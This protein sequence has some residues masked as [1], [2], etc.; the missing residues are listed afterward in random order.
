MADIRVFTYNLRV[1]VPGDGKNSFTSRRAY[2]RDRFPGFQADIVGFQETIPHMRQWL[3]ENFPEY[4]VCGLGRE[5][6]LQ[7]E[8]NPILFRRAAFDLAELDCFW[9]SDT[10]S[11]PGSR[12]ATDQS[13]CPRICT[14]ATVRH[15]DTGRLL[16]FYNTHLDHEGPTAQAQ[17]LTLILS[18]MAADYAKRPLP[19]VLTGDFNAFPDSL[20]YQSANGFS[21]CGGI[22]ADATQALGGTYHNFGRL[23]E[24]QKI[25][26]IFTTLPYKD[27]FLVK[28][29]QDGIYLSD[30]Y[31]AGAVVA[32]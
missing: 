15:R 2:I 20:V 30:H 23:D 14:C 3:A 29:S 13:G 4:E 16:R 21:G 31:P 6:D 26:Y 19:V 25:D 7:G 10:P 18:R 11:L 24:P 12:F 1:D 22:L 8:S 9:L 28:D 5:S 32:L 27:A 17:G